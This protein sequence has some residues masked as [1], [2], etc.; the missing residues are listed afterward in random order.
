MSATTRTPQQ[1][2]VVGL[3]ENVT[4]ATTLCQYCDALN[5]PHSRACPMGERYKQVQ[6][7]GGVLMKPLRGAELLAFFA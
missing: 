7:L 5:V 3:I 4:P 6:S 2:D 1:T